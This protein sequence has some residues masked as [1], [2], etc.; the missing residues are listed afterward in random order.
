LASAEA[1]VGMMPAAGHLEHMPAHIMQRVGRYEEAAEANRKGA[2]ADLAYLSES[3]PPDYYP[4]YLKHNFQFLSNSAAMEGRRAEAIAAAR[5][6]VE[7]AP[8]PMLIAMGNVDWSVGYLYDSMLRFGDWDGLLQ[9]PAPNP[10]LAG[11]TISWLQAQANALAARGRV[12]EAKA[13]AGEAAALAARVPDDAAQGMNKARALYRIG[14]LRAEARIALAERNPDAAIAAL[15]EASGLE[16]QLAY[17]EPSDFFFP[18][19]HLLGETLLKA[20]RAKEAEAVY[21]EDLRRNPENGWALHGLAQALAAQGKAAEAA[22]A[23]ARFDA[24]WR[25]AD[26]KIAGSAY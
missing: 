6:V 2:A 19:R 23:R 25:H 26:V 11:L 13:R 21:R 3:A 7:V 20:G 15:G 12:A 22:A 17:N 16:D 4:M 18:I 10:T 8:E 9:A 14:Q 5:K 24:A 1:L